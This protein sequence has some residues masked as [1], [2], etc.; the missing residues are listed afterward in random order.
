[1]PVRIITASDIDRIREIDR[2]AFRDDDQYAASYY[3]QIAASE[4]YDLLA[5]T[6]TNGTVAG[7]ALIDLS[8]LPPRIRSLSIDPAFQKSGYGRELLDAILEKYRGPID[9]LVEP[10]NAA[11][12]RLYRTR[13]FT[14]ATPDVEMP[15][16][17]RM[18]REPL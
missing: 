2:R 17:L 7:W 5:A 18:I 8:C 1:M 16:R 6:D 12:I 4:D 13:G 14:N 9:L 10:E 3:E 11:A 15:Q